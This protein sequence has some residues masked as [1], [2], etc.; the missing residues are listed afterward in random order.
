MN[1]LK[2][3]KVP[4]QFEKI[5]NLQSLCYCSETLPNGSRGNSN[6]GQSR[7]GSGGQNGPG[8]GNLGQNRR[9]GN[10]NQ[11][12]G[13]N[14]GLNIGQTGFG[15]NGRPGNRNQNGGSNFGLNIGQTGFGQNAY[16][17]LSSSIGKPINKGGKQVGN[18]FRQ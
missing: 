13:S 5:E 17:S 8:G 2:N 3:Q 9:P 6:G 18:P 4:N 11:N 14:Y 12:G 15:Q 1:D 7:T 10:R 16:S